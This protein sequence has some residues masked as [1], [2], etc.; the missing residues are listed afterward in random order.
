[1][2]V[3]L[4]C[5][6]C[7]CVYCTDYS[8]LY[9]IKNDTLNIQNL[10][11]INRKTIVHFAIKTTCAIKNNFESIAFEMRYVNNYLNINYRS[12]KEKKQPIL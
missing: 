2:S 11:K 10:Q 8:I 4:L 3:C 12:R 9:N 6:L 5:V 7:V 1:M